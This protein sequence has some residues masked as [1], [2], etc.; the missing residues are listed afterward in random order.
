[1]TMHDFCGTGANLNPIK[2]FVKCFC[3]KYDDRF[4]SYNAFFSFNTFDDFDPS[5]VYQQMCFC[6]KTHFTDVLFCENKSR[7]S[8]IA[9]RLFDEF[10]FCIKRS[11]SNQIFSTSNLRGYVTRDIFSLLWA[12]GIFRTR[13]FPMFFL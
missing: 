8:S 6:L 13:R 5:V 4:N 3:H 12:V 2:I 7:T 10:F 1:M 11:F 9:R